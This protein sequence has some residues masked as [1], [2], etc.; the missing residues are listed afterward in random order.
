MIPRAK[1]KENKEPK[2]L[3]PKWKTRTGINIKEKLKI[4]TSINAYDIIKTSHA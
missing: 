3:S 2:Y 4:I 1:K